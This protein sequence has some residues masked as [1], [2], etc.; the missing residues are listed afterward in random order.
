M[1]FVFFERTRE[2]EE[3]GKRGDEETQQGQPK[4]PR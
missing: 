1:G 4:G 2:K 3:R